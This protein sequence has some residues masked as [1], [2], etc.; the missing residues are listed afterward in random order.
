[1]Q[2]IQMLQQEEKIKLF[3]FF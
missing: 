3:S 2:Q 1:V